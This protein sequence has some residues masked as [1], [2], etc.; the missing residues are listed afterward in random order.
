MWRERERIERDGHYDRSSW[1]LCVG[2]LQVEGR[3]A[4][5]YMDISKRERERGATE[6]HCY[7]ADPW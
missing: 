6:I 7:H 4:L 1:E 2:V 5:V 3:V